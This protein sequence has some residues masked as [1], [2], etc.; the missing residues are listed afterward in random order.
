MENHGP[1]EQVAADVLCL[2][3]LI[4]NVCFVG[5][6]GA[7]AG[8]WAL[9]DTGVPNS[10]EHIVNAAAERFGADRSPA[11]IVLTHG[12]F[13]HVGAVEE[14][15]R[16]WG[17]PVYAHPMEMP[18]LTGHADYPPPD[19]SVGGGLMSLLSPLY[20]R[21]GIN[22]GDRVQPLPDNGSIPGLPGWRWIHTPGHT[23]GH[24]SLFRDADRVLIA[25][26]AFTTVKQ[27]SALAVMLQEKEIH[28]PPAYWT[29]D[30]A[31]AWESVQRL[32]ALDPAVVATGH[33]VPM[34][35]AE[36]SVQLRELAA[37]F[38]HL[39]VPEQGRYVEASLH[40]S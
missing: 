19:P 3:T 16:R 5:H 10:A 29:T 33:G 14:L 7:H 21:S 36:L 9:V 34:R 26:D 37:H 12:H 1:G 2:R 23:P 8:E 18:Y 6:H 30:W 22:L 15:V 17:V 35:G 25:G 20:P 27:E 11:V 31:A 40:K 28:G 38:D 32:Q 24:I 39:A 4:A 13:D